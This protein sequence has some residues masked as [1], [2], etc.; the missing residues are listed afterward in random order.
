MLCSIRMHHIISLPACC[1]QCQTRVAN[2]FNLHREPWYPVSV[3]HGTLLCWIRLFE[4]LQS[5][6]IMQHLSRPFPFLTGKRVFGTLL[7]YLC[8]TVPAYILATIWIPLEVLVV[9]IIR[10]HSCWKSIPK[11]SWLAYQYPL[12]QMQ[13]VSAVQG[14]CISSGVLLHLN[15]DNPCCF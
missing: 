10:D 9:K 11:C 6:Q 12:N 14:S 15:I 5:W 2:M 8:E 3:F 1:L 7:L 13:H 4:T